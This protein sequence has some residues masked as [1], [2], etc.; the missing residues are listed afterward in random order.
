MADNA[1]ASAAAITK[2]KKVK[3]ECNY[4]VSLEGKGKQLR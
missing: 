2:I 4:H 1:A 3:Y